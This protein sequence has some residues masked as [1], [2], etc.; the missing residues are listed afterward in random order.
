[1]IRDSEKK[2]AELNSINTVIAG[3]DLNTNLPLQGNG[4]KGIHL[5]LSKAAKSTKSNYLEIEWNTYGGPSI[6]IESITTKNAVVIARG[7]YQ[8]SKVSPHLTTLTLKPKLLFSTNNLEAYKFS[9]GVDSNVTVNISYS[10]FY[11]DMITEFWFYIPSTGDYVCGKTN[12]S[13]NYLTTKVEVPL[14]LY[15]NGNIYK[16]G[17]LFN[18][19]SQGSKVVIN[20]CS[21]VKVNGTRQTITNFEL[22]LVGV[23][24]YMNSAEPSGNSTIA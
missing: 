17:V 21:L 6:D 20:K 16:G 18:N 5:K 24:Q 1:M 19:Y 23:I 8:G 13:P 9:S 4:N 15:V 11:Y 3:T 2:Y 10:S 22:S 7:E 12:Y 14:T